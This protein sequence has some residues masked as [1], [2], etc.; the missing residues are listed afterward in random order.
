MACLDGEIAID[1]DITIE[2]GRG[3]WPLRIKADGLRFIKGQGRYA[4]SIA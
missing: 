3:T 1:G 4:D 2:D